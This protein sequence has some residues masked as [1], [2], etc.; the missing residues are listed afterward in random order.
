VGRGN[1]R[2]QEDARSVLVIHS[3]YRSTTRTVLNLSAGW[4]SGESSGAAFAN[5]ERSAVFRA[6]QEG[7]ESAPLAAVKTD[8]ACAVLA[9]ERRSAR[10]AMKLMEERGIETVA[11]GA[12]E[13]M[14]GCWSVREGSEG[15]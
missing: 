7:D 5:K 10:R 14:R 2:K 13:T 9:R 11:R 6:R 8:T 15:V 3:S 12:R 4:S 1:G